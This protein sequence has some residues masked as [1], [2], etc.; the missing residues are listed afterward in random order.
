MSEMKKNDQNTCTYETENGLQPYLEQ[1]HENKNSNRKKS[2]MAAM[3]ACCVL[4]SGIAGFS[5]G[6]VASKVST[7]EAAQTI[8]SATSQTTGG[9]YTTLSTRTGNLTVA[10]VAEKTA[11][12]VVEITTESVTTGG[13]WLQQ[14]VTSGAGSGVVFSEDGYIVTN[15]HVIEGATKITVRLHNGESYQAELIGTDDQ[16]DIALIKIEASG[17]TPAVLGDSDALIVGEEAIAVGNPLGELGGTVTNGIISALNREITLEGETMTLLQTNAAINP[18][19]SGGGLFNSRGEL[20][21]VVVAK[22]SGTGVEGL[23]FAIPV[24]E[25]KII[26]EQLR[27]NGYVTGRPLLGVS[28]IDITTMQDMIRYQVR[29]G[30]VYI[31]QVTGEAAANAGLLAGDCITAINGTEISGSEEVKAAVADSSVGDQLEMTI[32]RGTETMT[33]TVTIGEEKPASFQMGQS[34]TESL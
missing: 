3:M 31:Y 29:Q 33:I 4:F 15:N 19:N 24:N 20:V 6:F 8:S 23:G 13:A 18:G 5:G 1:K 7:T 11:N 34:A 21:G 17:L 10:Q 30:G 2:S 25:V 27:E 28:L 26:T 32:I 16:T 12:S 9:D 22:S 14:Y